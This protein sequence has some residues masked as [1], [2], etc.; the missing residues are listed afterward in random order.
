MDFGLLSFYYGGMKKNYI[1]RLIAA[2]IRPDDAFV[3]VNDFWRELDFDGLE[4]YVQIM[5]AKYQECMLIG[6]QIQ[7]K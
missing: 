1:D 3:I 2:G 7:S 4:D 6:I 5:E